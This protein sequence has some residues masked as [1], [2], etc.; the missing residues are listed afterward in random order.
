MNDSGGVFDFAALATLC[1][2]WPLDS[3][4][5]GVADDPLLER[6][7]QV[8]HRMR[9]SP[10]AAAGADLVPLIRHVLL[11]A[12]GEENSVPWLRVP[13]DAGWPSAEGWEE[14]QFDVLSDDA[15]L[16]IQ[17]RW[18][19][20]SFLPAQPD[21][22]DD[23][24]KGIFSRPRAVVPADPLLLDAMGLPT[25]T[26]DGQREAVR[27]L[28]HL[29]VGDT[30]IADLPTGSG[31][32]LLAHLPPLIGLEGMLTLAVVP[33]VALA[34]DQANRMRALL[35]RQS[36]NRA[37]PPLAFHGGL[38]LEDRTAVLRAVRQGAQ[39][40]LF[41]SP[42]YAVGCLREV[43][44][45][46]AANGRLKRVF[47]DEAHLVVGW[48][49]GFRPAFQLLPALVRVLRAKAPSNELRVVLASAT[50]TGAT[51][52]DLRSLFGPP[53][54]THVVSAVHL[55]PE[56]RY[57][58]VSCTEDARA[59]R[60]L[61]AIRL[62]PR[63]FILYVTRPDETDAWL[64]VLRETGL[65]RVEKFSGETSAPERERL[66]KQW[67]TNELDG[68]VATSAFG[69]GVDKS[70]VRTIIHATLPDSL[71]RFYQEVG[72][73]GRDG[74]AGSG[75][76][77]HTE[78]DHAQARDLAFPRLISDE[79]GHERWTVLIDHA[80]RHATMPDVWWVELARLP[81]HLRVQSDASRDWNVRTLTLMARAGLIE[82]VALAARG[83]ESDEAPQA[84]GDAT[85]AAIRILDDGHRHPQVFND[86]M[87]RARQH[88]WEAA[89]HGLAAIQSVANG[90]VE[91]SEAL[92]RMYSVNQ[93]VWIPVT[94]CCGGC[95]NHWVDRRERA[96]YRPPMALRLTRFA[97]RSL[98]R[99]DR[100]ALPRA[101]SNLLVIDVPS[102]LQYAETC[103]ALV[104]LLAPTVQCHTIAIESNFSRVNTSSIEQALPPSCR[105]DVFFDVV[106]ADAPEQW[107]AGLDEVRI[108]VWG[109]KTPPPVPDV[110]R[111]SNAQLEILVVPSALRHPQHPARRFIDTTPHV[112][113]PDV[114]HLVTS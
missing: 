45:D 87:S 114:L 25:Y 107:P 39:P 13:R 82:L 7:R 98:K 22:Y 51:I 92:C 112:H 36:H 33:T 42:E 62:A 106:N 76:L 88:V 68:M 27:A 34:I 97:H 96:R 79:K 63:P 6:V 74:R 73:A 75:L 17:P 46:A 101:A 3:V 23:A 24:F 59:G 21:L 102:E 61:E 41:T 52:R 30:L 15:A 66:L 89:E 110:L 31:K 113:A 95:P 93:G 28:L 111:L 105:A 11:R 37:L 35:Q 109:N 47:I 54:R 12:A 104:K 4:V 2:R 83:S 29:P 8:L 38:A 100:L 32:S 44:E 55:R 60:V 80:E 99:F 58:F 77:L 85:H 67:S 56:L 70:D 94:A 84:F 108:V 71:D 91:V 43:L 14:A 1:A 19:R 9:A 81:P 49:N 103:A 78:S 53:E 5:A 72:R 90:D 65:R 69:L 16:R 40:I 20:L 64:R 50:L 48:G 10:M 18:P 26:G 86:R 57:A